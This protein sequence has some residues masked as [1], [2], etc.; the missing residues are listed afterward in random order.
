MVYPA[1]LPLMRTTRLP[2]VDWTEAPAVLN[3]L[4][5]FA[6]RR[7]L[8]SERV[9]SK[10]SLS[11]GQEDFDPRASLDILKKTKCLDRVGSVW[12]FP[13]VLHIWY[14][15]SSL[16]WLSHTSLVMSWHLWGPHY[17][18]PCNHIYVG[19]YKYRVTQKN[20][21]FWKTQQKLKKSKKKKI[22][23]INFFFLDFFNF[24]WVF[25]K[26]PSFCVTLYYIFCVCL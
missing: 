25:Q 20:G 5:R 4:V 1:L 7:N 15:S 18:V 10:R 24:C 8:A 2:V 19:L 11:I 14:S 22:L 3:G 13:W 23:S 9:P 6:E 26:F 12:S 21:N 16:V 17:A